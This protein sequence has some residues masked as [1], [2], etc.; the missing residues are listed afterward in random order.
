MTTKKIFSNI[1]KKP[2]KFKYSFAGFVTYYNR[3]HQSSN[4]SS[5]AVL[6]IKLEKA[7][8]VNSLDIYFEKVLHLGFKEFLGLQDDLKILYRKYVH[9]CPTKNGVKT[10][11]RKKNQIKIE[12]FLKKVFRLGINTALKST[13]EFGNV[14]NP[15]QIRLLRLDVC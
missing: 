6:K 7:I 11:K 9:L 10:K 3:W 8:K 14:R 15:D 4:W 2:W 12:P 5:I 13:Q 1:E